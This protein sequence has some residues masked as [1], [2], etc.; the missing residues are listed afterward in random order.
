VNRSAPLKRWPG[1]VLLALVVMALLA[2]GATRSSGPRSPGDRADDLARRVACPVCDGESVFAS[3]NFASEAIRTEIRR[4]VNDGTASD[5][6][7]LGFIENRYGGEVLLVPRASGLDALVWALPVTALVC[8]L[9]GLAVTFRRWRSE[10][11]AAGD[12]T[13]ADRELVAAALTREREGVA[14]EAGE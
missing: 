3:R 4:L 10:A 14:P 7:I 9:V 2:V 6:E 8:A 1:W 13:D 5:D 11:R 12:P